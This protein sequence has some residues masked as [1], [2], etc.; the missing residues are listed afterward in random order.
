MQYIPIVSIEIFGITWN[1]HDLSPNSEAAASEGPTPG[2]WVPPSLRPSARVIL[3]RRR[4]LEG[5]IAP[6]FST[7]FVFDSPSVFGEIFDF[8]WRA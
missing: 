1:N 5:L 2:A 3:G 6:S 8:F 7:V 4:V